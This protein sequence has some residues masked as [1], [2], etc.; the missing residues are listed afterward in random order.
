MSK[1]LDSLSPGMGRSPKRGKNHAS[2]VLPVAKHPALSYWMLRGHE[3]LRGPVCLASGLG[4]IVHV[5]VEN[6]RNSEHQLETDSN[7]LSHHDGLSRS[8]ATAMGNSA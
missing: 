5:F 1:L 8:F 3:A 7:I 4:G 6:A 2:L